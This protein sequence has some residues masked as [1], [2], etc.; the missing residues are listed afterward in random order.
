M[1]Q[2]SDKQMPSQM[3]LGA[4]LPI[5]DVQSRP[6]VRMTPIDLVG[7]N[8][9]KF[10][11]VVSNKNGEKQHTVANLSMAVGLPHDVK[12]THMSRFIEIIN[13]YEGDINVHSLNTILTVLKGRLNASKA[14]IEAS[15]PYFMK[16]TSPVSGAQAL[17]DYECALAGEIDGTNEDYILT[18]KVPVTSLCP[19]S[20]EISD[21]GAHNQR[22]YLTIDVRSTLNSNGAPMT[23]WIDDLVEVAE[24]AASCP[25]YPLLKRPDERYITM[26]AFDNPVFVEDMVRDVATALKED[27]RVAWFSVRAENE[28]SIHNHNAFAYLEWARR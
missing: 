25:I 12:G 10:P 4:K 14:R 19:C 6:D 17:M 23:I 3:S 2:V 24:N 20:K 27:E 21:Y 22:G 28:E 11:I 1:L 8:D 16:R 9:I 5:E 7:V 13:A 26:K 15:F 18:V